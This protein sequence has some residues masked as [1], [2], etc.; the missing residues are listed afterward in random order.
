MTGLV[1]KQESTSAWLFVDDEDFE[2]YISAWRL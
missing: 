1:I 2:F